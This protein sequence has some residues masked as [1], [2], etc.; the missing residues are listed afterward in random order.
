[1]FSN[2]LLNI[3]RFFDSSVVGRKSRQH[4][5]EDI[6]MEIILYRI[7]EKHSGDLMW[8]YSRLVNSIITPILNSRLL[9]SMLICSY[10]VGPYTTIFPNKFL[11][12]G[13]YGLVDINQDDWR[14]NSSLWVFELSMCVW[15]RTRHNSLCGGTLGISASFQVPSWQAFC[16]TGGRFP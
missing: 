12:L 9:V 14:S 4:E 7:T 5:F 6:S 2:A 13:T 16:L 10:K 11:S 15:I 3:L 8:T 1:M